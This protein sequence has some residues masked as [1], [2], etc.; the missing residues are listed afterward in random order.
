MPNIVV[1][2]TVVIIINLMLIVVLLTKELLNHT[3]S[4]EPSLI[5]KGKST[6]HCGSKISSDA[7]QDNNTPS[8]HVFTSMITNTLNNGSCS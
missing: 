1:D 6:T 3:T 2:W 7:I 8:C 4:N 5:N